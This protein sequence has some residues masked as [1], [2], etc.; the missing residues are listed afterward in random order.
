MAETFSLLCNHFVLIADWQT[1]EHTAQISASKIWPVADKGACFRQN[2]SLEGVVIVV[3][4]YY[5]ITVGFQSTDLV[6]FCVAVK[7][8]FS[9]SSQSR[10]HSEIQGRRRC[11][12][13]VCTTTL[14][15]NE[16]F[17]GSLVRAEENFPC[18]ESR[19]LPFKFVEKS[20]PNYLGELFENLVRYLREK[21]KLFPQLC[22]TYIR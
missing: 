2:S 10:Y 1:I 5:L 14:R 11:S 21:L 18:S 9:Y 8:H 16:I 4:G 15:F 19:T 13:P 6:A 7:P 12:S 22:S 3:L 20:A 17:T